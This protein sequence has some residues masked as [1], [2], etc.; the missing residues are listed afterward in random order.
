MCVFYFSA[1]GHPHLVAFFAS[2]KDS[3]RFYLVLE[4]VPC[5]DVFEALRKR[6][7]AFTGRRGERR[8]GKWICQ[9]ANALQHIHSLGFIHRDV[10]PEN[11]FLDANDNVK[12]GDF[13][14]TTRVREQ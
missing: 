3:K 1:S 4:Y 5:Q 8:L 14:L 11:L 12:L 7:K 13:G 10:K 6:G 9:T 2:F